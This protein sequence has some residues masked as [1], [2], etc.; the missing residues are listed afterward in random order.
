[1]RKKFFC[2]M[3]VFLLLLFSDISLAN[4]M[5]M[6]EGLWEITVQM[7]MPGMS[8]QMPPQKFTQCITKD[9]AVPDDPNI[10]NK[11]CKMEDK[12]ITGDT[13]LWKVVCKDKEEKFT[14]EGKI[15]YKGNTFTG[16]IKMNTSDGIEMTQKMT[17]KWV[18][19]CQR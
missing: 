4:G 12:K 13:F 2:V 14:S 5:N 6:K 3:I 7:D 16:Q 17:G 9:K 11:D 19:Q 10:K 15:T 18:G 1:M 8:M